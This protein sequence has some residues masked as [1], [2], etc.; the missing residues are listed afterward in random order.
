MS[1][2]NF[3]NKESITSELGGATRKKENKP[4]KKKHTFTSSFKNQ[5]TLN[6]LGFSSTGNQLNTNSEKMKQKISVNQ[7][8]TLSKDKEIV[9]K[10]KEKMQK[11]NIFGPPVNPDEVKR[12]NTN[13]KYSNTLKSN[14]EFNLID[15][16]RK[17]PENPNL[18]YQP[19]YES[20]T[21]FTRKLREFYNSEKYKES[22]GNITT[23]TGTLKNEFLG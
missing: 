3:K 20:F 12:A 17:K 16:T 18:K 15:K 11:S 10:M 6:C 19:K 2:V 22:Y 1:H 7:K 9:M 5:E 4:L 13:N 21:P 14:I 23:T 8:P